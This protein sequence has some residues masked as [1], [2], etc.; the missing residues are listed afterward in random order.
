MYRIEKDAL[1]EVSIDINAL[2]GAQTA[3]AVSNFEI[4]DE[5]IDPVFIESLA[6]VKKACALGNLHV[7]SLQ[8]DK[9][10]A[11]IDVCDEIIRG[12]HRQWFVTKAIQ[13]GA[14]TSVNM[15][16]N[17]V[18]ANRAAQINGLELGRYTWIH[19]NDDVNHGQSTNDVI[20]TAGKITA[21]RML[22]ALCEDLE[23]I[24]ASFIKIAKENDD[25][26]KVGRTHLQDAVL[27]TMGQVFNSFA[28]VIGRNIKRLKHA[29]KELDAINLGATAVG[30][31]INT[32][33]GY[34]EEAV[35]T[36][37]QL[38]GLELESV[39]DLVDG[40]KNVDSFSFIHSCLK[41]LALDI[42]KI[43]ND[44]RLMASGPIAGFN[45]IILPAVQPGSSIMPGK[46]NPVILEVV[47]QT[48][49][50]VLGHD[51]TICFAHEAGQME[52]N[53]FEPVIFYNLFKSF[54]ILSNAVR[55]L[56]DKALIGLQVNREQ[57]E[58]QVEKSLAMATSLVEHLGYDKTSEIAKKALKEQKGLKQVVLEYG[59]LDE[60]IIDQTLKPIKMVRRESNNG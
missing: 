38:T 19:P 46:V 49:F 43:C 57:C 45:E 47:N 60:E 56:N 53:V 52:L 27:I 7:K 41:T 39:E 9:A 33:Y 34:R 51:A 10:Q 58:R 59:Y 12:E 48:C 44:L 31:E 23:L 26:V 1:G 15:N 8:S 11:I 37:K 55:T 35:S 3:R 50:Q 28:S 36:L 5:S 54:R 20:P 16:M 6:Y 2:Y 21:S 14:G 29:R 22:L 4:V 25:V 18:I 13:G 30:T 42:S 24:R 17:E 40:T 32:K